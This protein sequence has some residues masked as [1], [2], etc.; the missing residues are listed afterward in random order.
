MFRK[1]TTYSTPVDLIQDLS[2]HSTCI[3][4]PTSPNH[5]LQVKSIR[6]LLHIYFVY[7][8]FI[9]ITECC[10]S[11][12]DSD[13]YLGQPVFH[14][15]PTTSGETDLSNCTVFLTRN[16]KHIMVNGITIWWNVVRQW[17]EQINN[18]T[19]GFLLFMS[20]TD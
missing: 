20:L 9:G 2:I 12:N 17:N 3:L 1:N 4:A 5:C 8:T 18:R 13:S 16:F 6:L 19:P 15:T 7:C 10:F 11:E 14:S